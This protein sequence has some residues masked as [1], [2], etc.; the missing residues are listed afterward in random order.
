VRHWQTLASPSL[1]K[2]I[3]WNVEVKMNWDESRRYT[4]FLNLTETKVYRLSQSVTICSPMR[5]PSNERNDLANKRYV[6]S[7]WIYEA[8]WYLCRSLTDS[9]RPLTST[10]RSNWSSSSPMRSAL[11]RVTSVVV[12]LCLALMNDQHHSWLHRSISAK[13]P[14]ISSV[15]VAILK[16]PSILF[17]L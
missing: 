6:A 16:R 2:F 1:N 9:S 17:S 11:G 12:A 5:H 10:R 15:I 13:A 4:G 7:R 8:H 14:T 3:N